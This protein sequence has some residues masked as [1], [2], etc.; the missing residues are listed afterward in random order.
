M[1]EKT[2]YAHPEE[3]LL[4][5]RGLLRCLGAATAGRQAALVRLAGRDPLW[6]FREFYRPDIPQLA[7]LR[8]LDLKTYLPDNILVKVDRASMASSLEVRV[9]LLDHRVVEHVF[10]LHDSL[11]T[12]DGRSKYVFR[13]AMQDS[14]PDAILARSKRGFGSP[15]PV[16]LKAGLVGIS[17]QTWTRG[18]SS[19]RG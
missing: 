12:A 19:A 16:W 2:L 10:R 11:M 13:R 14:L 5:P 4:P 17:S 18:R 8:Y 6:L 9:P 3:G 15:V 1:L 7:A